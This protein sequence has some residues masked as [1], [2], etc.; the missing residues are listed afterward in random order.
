[1]WILIICIVLNALIGVIFKLFDTYKIDNLQAIVTNYFVCVITAAIVNGGNPIPQD[2]IDQP[3]FWF[4]LALGC[5]FIIVF[6]LMALTVQNFGVVVSTI[7][8]KMSLIAPTL[9]A[10][11]IYGESSNLIK[12]VG[13]ISSISAIVLLS[14]QKRVETD[15]PTNKN[16]I[17]WLFPIMT[18]LGS[19]VIDSALFLIEHNNLAQNGDIGFVASLF[20]S[21]GLNGLVILIIQLYRKKSKLAMRNIMGGIALGVPNFFSIYLLLLALQQGWGASVVF[22]VNNVGILVVAAIFGLVIFNERL[23]RTK[24]FGFLLAIVAIICITFA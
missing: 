8:Q 6:N 14:Y 18:F 21:A 22:P 11:L 5:I 9:I 17:V 24:V 4:A 2:I 16:S 12:W 1:M 23:T 19:C 3:W 10:I 13:I 7:F 20:L 15:S